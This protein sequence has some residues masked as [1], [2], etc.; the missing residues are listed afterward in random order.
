MRV[1]VPGLGV[2][3]RAGTEY[4]L[5][6]RLSE[7]APPDLLQPAITDG[8]AAAAAWL[9]ARGVTAP[10]A[11]PAL[12][13]AAGEAI[14]GPYHHL[15]FAADDLA[16]VSA[17]L[18][19]TGAQVLVRSDDAVLFDAGGS[20][21]VEIVRDADRQEPFWC[22][23]HPDMRSA[24][25]G[26]CRLCG[27][28]LVPI[29]PPRI[30]EYALDVAQVRSQAKRRTTGLRLTIRE[31]GTDTLVSRFS[32][33]HEKKLHLF[34]VTPDLE[35]FAHVHPEQVEGGTFMLQ[36]ELPAG[37]YLVVADFLPEGGTSQMVPKAII[38]TGTAST[39][40]RAT[41]AAAAGKHACLTF[42]VTDARSGEP[43]TDLQSYLGAPA[44]LFMIRADLRDAVHVHPEERVTQGPAVSFHPL[45]PAAGR[46]KVWVQFR[47]GGRI[48]T[49]S[50]E[51]TVDQ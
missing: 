7:S 14:R 29:P 36:H 50:F 6:D 24:E 38:V 15:A 8:Y 9:G 41:D 27:M 42:S 51:F 5:F 31:P 26:N 28:T 13:G 33:V 32:V 12:I 23:M 49:T 37:E 45:I 44:H 40:S 10:E 25:A 1:I 46:Y 30:G 17:R 43:V 35:Y 47:R 11:R 34:I 39:P 22:P 18:A 21:L 48:S 3:L 4:L 20:L 19:S 2:G 16:A